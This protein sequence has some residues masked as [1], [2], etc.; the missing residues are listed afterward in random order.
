MTRLLWISLLIMALFLVPCGQAAAADAPRIKFDKIEMNFPNIKEGQQLD[1]LFKFKNTGKLNL[2]I[3][4]VSPSCGCTVA[5]YD[6][7]TEPGKSGTVRLTLDTSGINGA[8]RKT[9]VV[10]TNDPSNPFITLVMT[11]ETASR[12]V[13]EGGRRVDV[14]GCLGTDVSNTVT[15][16]APGGGSLIIAGV[17]N[18]MKDYLEAKLEAVPGGKHYKLHLKAIATHPIEFAGPV[19]L[20]LPGQPRVSVFV[21]VEVRGPFTARPHEIYF[22]AIDK[23]KPAPS[24]TILLEK[25]CADTLSIDNLEYNANLLNIKQSWTKAGQRLLLTVSPRLKN[26]IP[27]RLQENISITS[28]GLTFKVLVRGAV[29]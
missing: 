19:Y 16:S 3:D 15:L 24:R 21:V 2:I 5:K 11:G 6:K 18:P 25:A 17:Q 13:V 4:D 7:V 26:L 27:G 1:A 14:I 23:N 9:A 28:H 8:F 22:G 12:V 20:I 29:K 10:A